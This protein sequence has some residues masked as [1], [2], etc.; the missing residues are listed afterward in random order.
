MAGE[1]A[2]SL[3]APEREMLAVRLDIDRAAALA[4]HPIS[5]FAVHCAR[6]RA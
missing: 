1:R 3:V 5:P 2:E 4:G 6:K